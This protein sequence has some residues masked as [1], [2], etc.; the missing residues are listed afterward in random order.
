MWFKKNKVWM[1]T[2]AQG[3]PVVNA[4]RVLIKYQLKQDQEYWVSQKNVRSLDDPPEPPRAAGK[5]RPTSGSNGRRTGKTGEDTI[6]TPADWEDKIC[7]FTD[8]ASSGNP[9]PSG[10]GILLRYGKHEREISQY[11]GIATN[12]I[13]ELKAIEAGLA[14]VKQTDIPVRVF[15]DSSYAH[16][17]LVLNWKPKKNQ[18]IVASVKK[19][20][21]RFKDLRIMKVRGHSGHPENEKADSLATS[22]AKCQR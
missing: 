22:A 12:N 13:A 15:T 5:D 11:I 19:A 7:V 4:G 9:G 1:A 17:L 16:G 18:E 14:A 21:A 20:M 6:C 10:I 2:D 8:G 3:K